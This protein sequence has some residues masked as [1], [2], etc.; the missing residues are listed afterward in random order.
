[1][2]R[3]SH[4]RPLL[5]VV[6]AL[7]VAASLGC[8]VNVREVIPAPSGLRAEAKAPDCHLDFFWTT[9]D[10]PY[11]ELAAVSL[12]SNNQGTEYS[13]YQAVLRRQACALGGDAVIGL[14]PFSA[15]EG[16]VVKYRPTANPS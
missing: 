1:M 10:R 14:L 5:L 8:A 2:Q 3:F 7:P 12:V 15:R 9:P 6:F 13:A 16:I 4:A 11:D